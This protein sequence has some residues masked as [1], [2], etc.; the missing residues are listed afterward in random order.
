MGQ[1]DP[2][3]TTA[4]DEARM[5]ELAHRHA[6]LEVERRLDPL[7][8]TLIAEP[9]YEFHPVKLCMRGGDLCRRYYAQFFDDFMNRV[10]GHELISEM[11]SPEAV[12]QEYDISLRVDGEVETHRVVGV[13]FAEGDL[14]GGERIYAS[15]RCIRLMAGRVFD[16]FEPL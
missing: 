2:T 13:L 4:W 5:I 12:A 15:E 6:Q 3:Q 8:E 1:D 11:T 7:M 9:V 10:V 14:L 16:E